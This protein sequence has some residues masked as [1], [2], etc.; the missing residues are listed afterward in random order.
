MRNTRRQASIVCCALTGW[1]RWP[2]LCEIPCCS[3]RSMRRLTTRRSKATPYSSNGSS[4]SSSGSTRRTR[5]R[6]STCCRL[7]CH[8]AGEH[9]S[10]NTA[11]G[12]PRNLEQPRNPVPCRRGLRRPVPAAQPRHAVRGH[13]DRRS[14][15]TQ[16]RRRRW[17]KP[18]SK[19]V[20]PIALASWLQPIHFAWHQRGLEP[21]VPLGVNRLRRRLRRANQPAA[22]SGSHDVDG[23]AP[24]AGFRRMQCHRCRRAQEHLLFGDQRL[25][26]RRRRPRGNRPP[27]LLVLEAGHIVGAWIDHGGGFLSW[28]C[29]KE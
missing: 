23:V 10:L 2:A 12:R 17:R 29:W 9:Y 21:D 14:R 22:H 24:S 4:N 20:S 5:P 6:C 19:V 18:F 15:T 28:P 16:P 26:L 1:Q 25:R 27:A 7:E 13:A 3:S 8:Q 11:G